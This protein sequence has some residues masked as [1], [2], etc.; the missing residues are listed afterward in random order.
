MRPMDVPAEGQSGASEALV[1][2]EVPARG[3]G[4]AG[5]S[6][7]GDSPTPPKGREGT[8]MWTMTSLAV[9]P[10]LEVSAIIF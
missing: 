2:P 1:L 3:G 5:A 7:R 10:P 9:T 8:V 4:H 6:R